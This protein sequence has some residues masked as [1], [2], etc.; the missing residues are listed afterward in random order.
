MVETRLGRWPVGRRIDISRTLLISL[1]PYS[2]VPILA[3]IGAATIDGYATKSSL[4]SL[5]ILSSFLGLASLGQTFTVIAGGVDLSIPAVIGMADVVITQLDGD[6]WPFWLAA[7]VILAIAA[8]IGAGNAVASLALRVH[9]L[10]VTLGMGLIVTGGVLVWSHDSISGSVPQWLV[11]SV[12]VIG[13]TGPIPI[14]AIVILWAALSVIT[15]FMQRRSRLGREIYATGANPSAARLALVRSRWAL[16]S[17]FVVAAVLAAVVGILFAGYSGAA[18]DTV[19][20]PYLF[21]TVTAVV[22]GGTSLLGGRGSYGRTIAGA[23]IISQLTTLLVGFGFGP[24]MQEVL[25]G[26]L[27]ILLVIIYG[28]ESHVS[29]RV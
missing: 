24:S 7:L 27:I 17:A 9:P 5:L 22:V 3:L 23:L 21:E 13:K 6:R 18:D 16:I 14:P 12:S 25:L 26:I 29:T 15:I 2:L 19:G 8:V 28:R 4:V 10:I 20:Q 11:T 1:I